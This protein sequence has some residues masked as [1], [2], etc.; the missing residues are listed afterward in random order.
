[1]LHASSCII[2]H[3]P[4]PQVLNAAWHV[5]LRDKPNRTL[6]RLLTLACFKLISPFLPSTGPS[7]VDD[8]PAETLRA[9]SIFIEIADLNAASVQ[10]RPSLLTVVRLVLAVRSGNA[11]VACA[12][13]RELLMSH[14]PPSHPL[15]SAHRQ[16]QQQ[17]QLGAPIDPFHC[18]KFIHRL[19]SASNMTSEL[20]DLLCTLLHASKSSGQ[21][22][23]PALFDDAF[24]ACLQCDRFLGHGGALQLLLDH[25]NPHGGPQEA[26]YEMILER[27]VIG[28]R[29]DVLKDGRVVQVLLLR[30]LA[31]VSRAASRTSLRSASCMQ[32]CHVT[33]C[34]ACAGLLPKAQCR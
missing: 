9:C 8:I 3:N 18:Y 17:Q 19:F 10:A 30:W 22:A 21:P 20:C 24:S 29:L 28:R 32:A 4:L 27:A 26:F 12:C 23:F 16:Q 5:C 34:A 2:V 25:P 31:D 13:A 11:A 14:Q 6:L 15:S 1:L 33:L 7:L